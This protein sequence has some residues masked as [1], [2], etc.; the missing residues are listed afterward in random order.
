MVYNVLTQY[1]YLQD[2]LYTV[3]VYRSDK[4]R[5]DLKEQVL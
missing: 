4:H 1:H 5:S 3:Y 2:R